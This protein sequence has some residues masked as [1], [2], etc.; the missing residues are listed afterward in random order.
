VDLTLIAVSGLAA[1]ALVAGVLVWRNRQRRRLLGELAD[2]PARVVNPRLYTKL[3]R[4]RVWQLNVEQPAKAC[5]WARDA[6]GQRFRAESSVPLPIA[7]CGKQ[8]RC[9]YEPIT[10][11]RRHKRRVDPID[12]PELSLGQSGTDRRQVRGRRKEDQWQG[13]QR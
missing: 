5:S 6:R 10:E 4:I 11:N 9:R 1:A 8:C 2:L 12:Q 3:R 13:T 7:G